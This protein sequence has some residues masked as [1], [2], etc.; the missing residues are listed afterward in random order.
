[1][2]TNTKRRTIEFNS[3]KKNDERSQCSG[4]INWDGFC[5][6]MI[7][8]NDEI[9]VKKKKIRS[10]NWQEKDNL[11]SEAKKPNRGFDDYVKRIWHLSRWKRQRWETPILNEV[12][13]ANTSLPVQFSRY[14]PTSDCTWPE[15]RSI[16]CVRA[17]LLEKQ[18]KSMVRDEE[19]GQKVS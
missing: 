17:T 1:M 10:G 9:P 12:F 2:M 16:A 11:D 18:T 4:V 6:A 3:N 13:C 14:D 5:S 15:F 19:R 8:G 7:W